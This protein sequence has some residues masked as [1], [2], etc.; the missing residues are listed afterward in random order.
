MRTLSITISAEMSGRK[1]K[2]LLHRE[3][4]MPDGLIA[5]VKLREKGIML[6]GQRCRTVDTVREGDTLT[7]EVGDEPAETGT[8]PMACPLKVLYEDADCIVIDKA[9]GMACHGESER[10]DCTVAAALAHRWGTRAAFHPVSRLDKGTSG[11]MCAAKSGYAHTLFRALLHTEDY[12][13]EYLLVCSPPPSEAKGRIALPIA[14]ESEGGIKRR[15]APEGSPALTEYEVLAVEGGLALVRARLHTG[16]THQIRV[17]F[18]AIGS[19][20]VGDWLY[21][22]A[23]ER[24]TRPALHS[25]YLSM[26]QPVTGKR[27]VLR[28]ALPQDMAALGSGF[29]E[30]AEKAF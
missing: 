17:H 23:S 20:L 16:R 3:L 8:K 7:V 11:I 24:I 21:G 5:R 26:L 19:P 22:E 1:V 25:A 27:L 14:R 2:S 30:K 10:G 28:S 29:A 4:R 18:A 12:R 9:A 6:N 13:R 15:V